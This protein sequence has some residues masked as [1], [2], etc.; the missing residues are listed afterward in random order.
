MSSKQL[1]GNQKRIKK[2][3]EEMIAQNLRGSLNKYFSQKNDASQENLV[4]NEFDQQIHSEQLI[5]EE[6]GV[7]EQI[8]YQ[9]SS[10]NENNKKPMIIL[11]FVL[12]NMLSINLNVQ[13]QYCM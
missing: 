8:S 2:K 13:S 4:E 3:N 12:K 5:E 9:E 11:F 7:D 6:N 1:F 10:E